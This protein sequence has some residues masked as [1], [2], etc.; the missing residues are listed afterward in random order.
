MELTQVKVTRFTE[1][2][3]RAQ[4]EAYIA[5][6][7]KPKP[8]PTPASVSHEKDKPK[9]QRLTAEEELYR[10][11]WA[12]LLDMISKGRL[13]PLKTFWEREAASLGGVDSPIPEWTGDRHVSLLQ[14]AAQSGHEDIVRWLLYDL[15]ADPTI[16]VSSSWSKIDDIESEL[17]TSDS[18]PLPS[19]VRR[20]AYDLAHSRAV[21]DV[22]R[23]CAA[24]HPGRWDWFGAARIPSAL[25]K[26][27]EEERDDKSKQR[28]KVL[29]DKMREREAREKQRNREVVEVAIQEPLA[30]PT[31]EPREGPQKLGGSSGALDGVAGLTP[32][33]RARV[34]RERRAR[35]AEVRLALLNQR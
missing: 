34:E 31:Q 4:D 2:E 27:K 16:P 24:D 29:R 26:E 1:E 28:K 5:S 33:M 23:R 10:G 13:E 3:L 35:A 15:C 8:R 9:P 17:A 12:R 32:E 14:V 21:R 30:K 19:T 20:T 7:P 18:L 25:S 11:K 22:F 6:L